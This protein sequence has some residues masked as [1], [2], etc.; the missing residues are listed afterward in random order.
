MYW[1]K[2]LKKLVTVK[3]KYPFP[4]VDDLFYQ[5]RVSKVFSKLDLGSGDHQVR[6]KD[7]NVHRTTF[8][9]RYGSYDL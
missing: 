9:A 1:L 6:V 3:N 2:Q 7:E 5:V 8:R 4:R